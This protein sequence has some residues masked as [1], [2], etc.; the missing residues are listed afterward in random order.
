MV[1]SKPPKST[2]PPKASGKPRKSS[3][4][5]VSKA[6]KP[7]RKADRPAKSFKIIPWSGSDEGEKI[8]LYGKS[9]IG[10]TTLAAL[11]PNPVFIGVDDGGRKIGHPVTGEPVQVVEGIEDFQDVRDALA[12]DELWPEGCTIVVDTLTKMEEWIQ[13]YV[14]ETT[15]VNGKHVTS[16]RKFGWDG[17]RYTL[18]QVRNLLTDLDRHSRAGRNVILLCQQGQIR[19][20]NA[21][22]SDYLEDGP[23]LQHRNDCSAREEVKQ[24]ADHVGRVGYLALEVATEKGSK[25]GK[26]ISDDATRAVFTGGAQHFTAKSRPINGNRIPPVISFEEPTDGSLWDYIFGDAAEA[27]D[28]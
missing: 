21:E 18:D 2:K 4:S 5:K 10:K 27:T 16:F 24:W 7:G 1:P 9:G 12:Q 28:E 6:S 3:P 15:T 14:L 23:F 20:A 19:V 17:D 11:A 22:G 13:N 8:V 25:A 26:V